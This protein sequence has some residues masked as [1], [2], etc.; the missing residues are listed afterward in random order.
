MIQL[1]MDNGAGELINM[2]DDRN[3]AGIHIVPAV[4]MASGYNPLVNPEPILKTLLRNG[5]DPNQRNAEGCTFLHLLASHGFEGSFSADFRSYINLALE[6]GADLEAKDAIGRTA[7]NRAALATVSSLEIFLTTRA[8]PNAREKQ[9]R[10]ASSS[11]GCKTRT[12]GQ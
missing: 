12:N 4:I 10:H 7:C 2:P 11:S 9:R 1:L 8:D 5:A 6:Y 3:N